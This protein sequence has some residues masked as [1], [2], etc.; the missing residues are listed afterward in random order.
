M[1][2]HN[3]RKLLSRGLM[4]LEERERGRGRESKDTS[5]SR[6]RSFIMNPVESYERIST[7]PQ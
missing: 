2:N 6:T 7:P 1:T 3:Y 4:Y 5:V